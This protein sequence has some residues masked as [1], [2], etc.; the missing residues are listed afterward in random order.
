MGGDGVVAICLATPSGGALLEPVVNR[1]GGNRWGQFIEGT[2]FADELAR[3]MNDAVD[4]AAVGSSHPVI[5]V[6][7]MRPDVADR[8][9]G[10]F[11]AH[12]NAMTRG[13][14]YVDFSPRRVYP[15]SRH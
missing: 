15:K 5:E 9:A 8:I 7:R 13:V 3:E 2:V 12:G 11:S 14:G 4:V 10:D 1:L 6:T